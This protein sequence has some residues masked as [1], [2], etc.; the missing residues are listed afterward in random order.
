MVPLSFLAISEASAQQTYTIQNWPSELDRVPCEAWKR[1]PDGSIG[2][3]GTIIVGRTK[4]SGK[5]LKNTV[6]AGMIEKKCS[7]VLK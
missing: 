2:Q 4:M 5:S 7:A 6:E 3:T 1:N